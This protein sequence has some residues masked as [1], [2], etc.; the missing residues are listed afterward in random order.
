[1]WIFVCLT[2]QLCVSKGKYNNKKSHHKRTKGNRIFAT[3]RTT[4]FL[5][6]FQNAVQEFET[7]CQAISHFYCQSCQRIGITI[8]QSH[9]NES[10]CTLCQGSKSKNEN[11]IE[12][13]PI[14]FDKHGLV[15][16]HLPKELQNLRE[17]E[18][19]LIQQVS[20]YVPLLHLKDGQIGSRGHVCSFVQ[21]ISSIC[22]V[23]PR[24]PND[25]H[26]I[27]VVKKYLQ[28]GGEVVSKMFSIRKD[29]VLD[30]LR[31]LKEHNLEYTNIEIKESNLDWIENN[32]EQELPP[33]LIQLD[34]EGIS[35]LPG[36]VDMGPSHSQTLSGLQYN[37]QEEEEAHTVLGLLPSLSAHLPKEKDAH[38]V[39]SLINELDH[40]NKNH[41]TTIQFPYA[42]PE[43]INE[44]EQ[45]NS[46]FTRAFPWLFPGGF[47]DFGQFRDK[48]ITV[49]DWAR[50]L[51][52]YKDGR[53]AKDRIWCFFVLDFATRKKN[54]M[55]G[56]FFVDGFFKE[57][58]KT[59]EQLQSDIADGNTS[60]L[61]RLCYYS[62]RVTGSPG[63]WRAK[64]AEVYSWIN[65]HVEAGNGPPLFFITLSCAEYM[66]PDIKRLISEQLVLAGLDVPC[67]DKS[68]IQLVNDYTLVVQEY[69]QERVKIWLSSIG[70]KVFHIKHYWLRY[71]FAPSRGQ[72]HA[73]ILAIHENFSILQ[74]YFELRT[75][76]KKQA[77][78]LHD[79]MTK[80][81]GMTAWFPES[82]MKTNFD[83]KPHP[84][85]C[86]FQDILLRQD[87]DF[88]CCLQKLQMHKCS[89]YCMQKCCY[90]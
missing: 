72:I 6:D 83:N 9:K 62:Q 38:I 33:S 23:L 3:E 64:R 69:F 65:Y 8:K 30:A 43:P 19:L 80:N 34:D 18:K 47:G 76:K 28:E 49:G 67:L 1:M 29:S 11:R 12:D 82:Y 16:Y 42:L 77:D 41:Q 59:L 35:N 2:D 87:E 88:A 74:P 61:E 54:Q 25:V 78:F 73:H 17:G 45:D 84:S 7:K 81:L 57:G 89:A 5:P 36:S 20:A 50:N 68:F 37:S 15:Q 66:W 10:L 63:Y 21:D 40:S 22:T 85:K 60:W 39:K 90:L 79:W 56:G 55:S 58:P 14:W 46:L 26:F 13:F 44:Y 31:W 71:E 24:L 86:L 75:D 32:K 53:F 27:K 48:K 51:L 52:Y 4:S 70:T